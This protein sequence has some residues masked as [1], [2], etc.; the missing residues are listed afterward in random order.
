MGLSDGLELTK[1][2]CP[3]NNIVFRQVQDV[4]I[5]YLRSH[6]ERRQ[7]SAANLGQLSLKEAFPCT[8]P[9]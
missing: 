5:N 7:F 4:V 3:S 8:G 9:N 6:P 1:E 2:I